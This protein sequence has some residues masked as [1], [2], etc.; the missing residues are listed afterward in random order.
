MQNLWVWPVLCEI[1]NHEWPENSERKT[2]QGNNINREVEKPLALLASPKRD[3]SRVESCHNCDM[4]MSPQSC[5]WRFNNKTWWKWW[6]KGKDWPQVTPHPAPAPWL[7]SWPAPLLNS[8]LTPWPTS[9]PTPG[10]NPWVNTWLTPW[11]TPWPSSWL[12]Q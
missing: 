11:F 5:C 7:T 12:S 6:S 1:Q 4:E 2:A 3:H 8:W 9:G 10:P